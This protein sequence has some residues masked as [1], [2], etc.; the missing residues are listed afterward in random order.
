MIHA[1]VPTDRCQSGVSGEKM[2]SSICGTVYPDGKQCKQI[3]TSL[4]TQELIPDGLQSYIYERQT[5][6]TFRRKCERMY[7]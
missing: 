4:H 3:L 7:L 1:H 2:V 5:F 6:K